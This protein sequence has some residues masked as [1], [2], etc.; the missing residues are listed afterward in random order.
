[1][2]TSPPRPS[3]LAVAAIVAAV[4]VPLLWPGDIP[5]INDE[6][7]LIA[8]AARANAEHR[9]AP[10]GLQG[11]YGFT[12][13]PAPTWVYQ[14]LLSIS[15]DLVV[16]SV[17]H[18][19]L[20]SVIT[21]AS[22]WWLAR[23]LGLW[24]WFLPVPLISPYFWFYARVLWDNPF[25]L[26]LGALTVAGYAAFLA[27]GSSTGLRVSWGGLL[28]VP[29]VH[30]MGLA[31][32]I[33]LA[34]HMVLCHWQAL[35]RHRWS[36]ATM[37]AAVVA[38]AQPYVSYLL[39]PRPESP[40]GDG[41]LA[42]WV[43]PLLGGRLLSAARLDYFFGPQFVDG[44]V[45]AATAMLSTVAYALVWAGL[46]AA[47]LL[48]AAAVRQRT[49]SPAAHLAAIALGA[50]L[51]QSLADG[52]SSRYQHPHYQNG[53]WI[54]FVLLAWLAVDALAARGGAIR[55]TAGLVTGVLAG[56]LM[57]TVA[58]L[59]IEVRRHGGTRE[60]YGPTLANQL[61]VAGALARHG[62]GSTV[63]I[64][65]AMWERFPHTPDIL[66]E[67][68][69]HRYVH[70]PQRDFLVRHASADESSGVIELVDRSR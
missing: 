15:R 30:L 66:R 53:T 70:G 32:V 60:V 18:A 14:A 29:L 63:E 24:I 56:S 36:L 45:F 42:G 20:M 1:M 26:P 7:Q 49:W 46:L 48:I 47:G 67:F 41:S 13:G 11:T 21:A 64:R 43:F 5:F 33:P 19:A 62:P 54:V 68:L 65:V 44:P 25:L 6:P 51:C 58:A 37:A 16:V 22:L 52:I 17:M 12:Y 57:L 3:R 4:L 59:A 38:A 31:L 10:I 23:S 8:N 39:T 40:P 27:T 69:R 2:A 35:W 9:L 55:H 34:A 50:L 61:Q 28:L